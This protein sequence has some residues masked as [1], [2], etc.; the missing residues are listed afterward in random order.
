MT[1]GWEKKENG[2]I[3]GLETSQDSGGTVP[4]W[5]KLEHE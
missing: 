2:G 4:H 5:E 1:G 3:Q